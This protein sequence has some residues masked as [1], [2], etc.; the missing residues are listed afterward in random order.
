M[1]NSVF[2]IKITDYKLTIQADRSE[3]ELQRVQNDFAQTNLMKWKSMHRWSTPKSV[4]RDCRSVSRN[5]A[6]NKDQSVVPVLKF[7]INVSYMYWY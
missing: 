4:V 3:G 6:E 1:H 2:W 7:K 5:H